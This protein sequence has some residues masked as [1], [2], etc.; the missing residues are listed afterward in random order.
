[1]TQQLAERSPLCAG[2]CIVGHSVQAD[3]V[4]AFPQPVERIQ[5]TNRGM[6]LKNADILFKVGQAH[7]SRQAGH[8]GTDDD[9]VITHSF[10]LQTSAWT[11]IQA[12]TATSFRRGS[13]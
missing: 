8:S 1:M 13:K 6:P 4:V 10:D 3:V 11:E 7:A 12:S 2:F 9:G 5:T